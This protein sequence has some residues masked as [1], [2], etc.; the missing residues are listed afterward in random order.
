[1]STCDI[2][3]KTNCKGREN[4]VNKLLQ[5]IILTLFMSTATFASSFSSAIN[6]VF[7]DATNYFTFS[8]SFNS[9]SNTIT[10]SNVTR[11][12]EVYGDGEAYP[13]VIPGSKTVTNGDTDI[14]YTIV[15]QDTN[16]GSS[17]IIFRFG[18]S[19]YPVA[20]TLSDISAPENCRY[21]FY[22]CDG[23]GYEQCKGYGLFVS[24]MSFSNKT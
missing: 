3:G 9:N 12:G 14:T 10:L 11:N 19:N 8:G 2:F 24:G 23:F 22:Y 7:G 13:L 18:S 20:L 17:N 5:L 16:T 1:M 15:L 6:A 21:M 4:F